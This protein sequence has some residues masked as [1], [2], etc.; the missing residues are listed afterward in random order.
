MAACSCTLSR[1]SLSKSDL[2]LGL[3]QR[4]LDLKW[5][6]CEMQGGMLSWRE[7]VLGVCLIQYY[8]DEKLKVSHCLL[9]A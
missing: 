9:L 6:L 7:T 5:R 4:H 1:P 3:A 8:D 2:S